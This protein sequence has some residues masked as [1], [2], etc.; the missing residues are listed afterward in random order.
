MDNGSSK[1]SSRQAKGMR[2]LLGPGERFLA[3]LERL[4]GIAQIP[5]GSTGPGEA[6]RL[7][8]RAIAKDLGV[9]WLSVIQGYRLLRICSLLDKLAKQEKGLRQHRVRPHEKIGIVQ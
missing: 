5:Q 1:Q 4:V 2:Q 7:G 3:A 9:R 8:I 6:D